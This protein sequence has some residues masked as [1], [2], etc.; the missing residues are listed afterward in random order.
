MDDL[1]QAGTIALHL[2]S[3]LLVPAT[4]LRFAVEHR[5]LR[6]LQLS[7]TVFLGWALLFYLAQYLPW[8]YLGL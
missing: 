5:I 3:I 2:A 1:S 8:T 7:G 4:I 6:Y